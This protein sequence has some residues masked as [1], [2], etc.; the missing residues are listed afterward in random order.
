MIS[1]LAGKDSY[2]VLDDIKDSLDPKILQKTSEEVFRIY[3]KNDENIVPLN[4]ILNCKFE[5]WQTNPQCLRSLYSDSALVR[6][7]KSGEQKM[8]VEER[9]GRDLQRLLRNQETTAA[10]LQASIAKQ[11]LHQQSAVI[12]ANNEIVSK[13]GKGETDSNK[14]MKLMTVRIKNELN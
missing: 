8:R 5:K 6:R 9:K 1:R 14:Q 12:K 2:L 10:L 13:V 11:K 7:N 3:K 4:E